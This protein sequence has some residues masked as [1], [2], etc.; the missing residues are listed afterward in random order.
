MVINR[1]LPSSPGEADED[2]WRPPILQTVALDGTGV[3]KVLE[4]VAAHH[5]HL[6][7]TGLWAKRERMRVEAQLFGVMQKELLD[8][9]LAREGE[10]GIRGWVER[11][12]AREVDVYTAVQTMLDADF[13]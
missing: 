9:V 12:A 8:R 10:A 1:N 4:A 2:A 11:I 7:A 5:E 6:R 13:H 3:S